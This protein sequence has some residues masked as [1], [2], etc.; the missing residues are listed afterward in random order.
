MK[1]LLVIMLAALMLISLVACEKSADVGSG[2]PT[3]AATGTPGDGSADGTPDAS[4]APSENAGNPK[5]IIQSEPNTSYEITWIAI[6][7]TKGTIEIT[8]SDTAT[9]EDLE[10]SGFNAPLTMKETV[11]YDVTYTKDAQGVYT[12]TGADAAVEMTIEGADAAA[13]K[14]AMIAVYEQEE[15]D[16]S[17]LTVRALKGE[18]LTGENV[19]KYTYEIDGTIEITFTL[20]DGEMTVQEFTKT[21]TEWGSMTPIK[22]V[23]KIEAGVLRVVEEYEREELSK[24]TYYRANGVIEKEVY[25]YE[26][27]ESGVTN[28]DENGEE[29]E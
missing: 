5:A 19:Q 7:G 20:E 11:S 24:R 14:Q 13:F 9:E 27:K 21:Y 22:E 18:K 29:I 10:G 2:D 26:G 1:R 12:A 25:Y 8:S 23:Y 6:D 4:E 16:L 17:K 28:Y 15:D 3:A